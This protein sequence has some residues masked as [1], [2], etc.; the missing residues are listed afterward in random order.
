MIIDC[1]GHYTAAP[2]EAEAWRKLQVPALGNPSRAPS[3]FGFVG[4]NLNPD[5]SGGHWKE[6]PLTDKW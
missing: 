2:A 4:C 1:H 5:P 6:P 3:E